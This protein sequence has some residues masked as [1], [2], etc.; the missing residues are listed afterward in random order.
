MHFPIHFQI[1]IQIFT[2]RLLDINI[3]SFLAITLSVIPKFML[4]L[5][6]YTNICRPRQSGILSCVCGLCVG[7]FLF[8]FEPDHLFRHVVWC[9][10]MYYGHV[11]LSYY[12]VLYA[13]V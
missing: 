6:N 5:F 3:S 8:V 13:Y 12:F 7:D 9:V 10:F 11:L 2:M 4:A 1:P